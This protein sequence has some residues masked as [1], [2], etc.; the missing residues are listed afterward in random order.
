MSKDRNT[1]ILIGISTLFVTAWCAT[2][3]FGGLSLMEIPTLGTDVS[4]E[5]RAITQDGQYVVGL[6]GTAS[7][8]KGFFY[9]VTNGVLQ[10]P[11]SYNNGAA[12]T[13]ATG[14]GY[15]TDNNQSPALVQVVVDG[16]TTSGHTDWETSDNGLTWGFKRRN[17]SY[18]T[19]YKLPGGNS[20]A[21]TTASDV[22][23][24][25]FGA[26]GENNAITCRGS[27]LWDTVTAAECTYVSKSSTTDKII[28]YGIAT[29]G[30]IVGFRK[31]SGAINGNNTLYDYPNSSGTQWQFNGLAGTL[32]GE[33]WAVSYDGTRIFGRS[34]VTAGD[35]NLY[36]Y[37]AVVTAGPPNSETSINAL[38]EIPRVGGSPTRCV[39]YGCTA[40]GKY[41]VGYAYP[42]ATLAVLWD[43]SDPNPANWKATDLTALAAANGAGV[44]GLFSA[45]TK[46]YSVGTNATEVVI[47]GYGVDAISGY[48]RAFLMTVPKSMAAAGFSFAPKLTFSGSYPAGLTLSFFTEPG[49][50]NHLEYTTNLNPTPTWTEIS[51]NYVGNT[52][53]TITVPDA[54]PTDQQRFY[55]VRIDP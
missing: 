35:T 13:I 15:R 20:L 41:A 7:T 28:P 47:T 29:N 48:T 21:A 54:N 30:R 34:P 1:P 3:T 36:A 2:N 9:I 8:A 37:K 31:A 6:S 49:T 5:G 14:V 45:L 24:T 38:P 10:Q 19:D 22:F 23:F 32:E 42:H 26:V 17:T 52:G 43:T 50:T 25:V 33:A 11:I 4:N 44:P 46:A 39:P 16:W 51:S 55:R 53:T 12:A 18:N 40:D 27:N